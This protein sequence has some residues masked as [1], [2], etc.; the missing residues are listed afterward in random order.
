MN[1]SRY[2]SIASLCVAVFAGC[3]EQPQATPSAVGSS[4]SAAVSPE[5]NTRSTTV[6]NAKPS[7]NVVARPA[8]SAAPAPSGFTCRV[9]SSGNP[10][11]NGPCDFKKEGG[12][13]SFS[14][15]PI[16]ASAIGGATSVSVNITAPSEAEVRGLTAEG[17][18]SRWGEAKRS[19]TDKAC[20]TGSDFEVCVYA[21]AA[22]SA[23]PFAAKAVA[24]KQGDEVWAVYTAKGTLEDPAVKAS[25]EALKKRGFE[26]GKTF[27]H[28]SLGCDQGAAKAL[29][30]PDT[31]NAVAVYFAN[32]ADAKAFA[33][34]VTP[35][36][37]GIAKIKAMCRD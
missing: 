20:W 37:L 35:P 6:V 36:A 15:T 24:Q 22:P 31:T 14:V 23:D 33:P 28:G 30:E 26:F 13:G 10:A 9:K 7:A 12:N 4:K 5:A 17:V 1:L 27:G 8:P 3:N 19:T 21:G 11:Y 29:N 16:G 25:I 32:E 2:G 18:N 34:T